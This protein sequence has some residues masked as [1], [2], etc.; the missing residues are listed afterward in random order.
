MIAEIWK[1]RNLFLPRNAYLTSRISPSALFGPGNR[2]NL[3]LTAFGSH[4]IIFRFRGANETSQLRLSRTSSRLGLRRSRAEP[5]ASCC[6]RVSPRTE[7][8]P[9][10][11]GAFLSRRRLLRFHDGPYLRAAVREHQQGR[12]RQPSH[13]LLQKGLRP[14]PQVPGHWRAARRDVLEGPADS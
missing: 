8:E 10:G 6:A 7:C 11:R 12:I 4:G 3:L 14:R 1:E 13:R 2:A 5:R 9:R